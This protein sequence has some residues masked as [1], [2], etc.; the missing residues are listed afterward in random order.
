MAYDQAALTRLMRND[1]DPGNRRRVVTILEYLAIQ[2]GD[3]VLDCGCGLGWFLAVAG[4]LCDC[5]LYGIDIDRGRIRRAA[6]EVSSRTHLVQARGDRLPFGDESFDKVVLSEVLEHVPDDAALLAE[7]RRVL[8]PGGVLAITV[9]HSRYPFLWD[10]I[11]WSRERLG[12][13]PIR[14]GPFGGIWTDHLRL[15]TPADLAA[16][17]S[18]V[19]LSV[20]DVRPLV[21]Y[22]LPFAHN[23]IYGLGKPLVES[24]LLP[25]ADRFRYRDNSG[26]KLNPLNWALGLVNAIDRLDQ[27]RPR[28][29][30]PSVCLGLKAR[31]A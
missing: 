17:V 30:A 21:R 10:P 15:Y 20:E 8:V 6:G 24:G 12:L 27:S 29:D 9:P 5:S 16:L 3:R 28:P 19:P 25:S 4:Q 11:N 26:S 31:K 18:G 7:V 2:R 23:L 1:A 14:H 13:A 22:C